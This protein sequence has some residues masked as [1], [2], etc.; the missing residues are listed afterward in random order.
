MK[1]AASAVLLVAMAAA[2][3]PPLPRKSPEFTIV[4]A[5]GQQTLLSSYKGKVV[6]LGFVH[7]TNVTAFGVEIATMLA[8]G[9]VA[10]WIGAAYLSRIPK[11]KITQVRMMHVL[12][13]PHIDFLGKRFIELRDAMHDLA[14]VEFGHILP[15]LP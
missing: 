12:K 2:A 15:R 14:A 1:R 9:I 10:A 13:Q 11:T 3:M 7:T 8:G 5:S 6:V 4:D